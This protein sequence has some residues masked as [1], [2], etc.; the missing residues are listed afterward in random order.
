MKNKR[1]NNDT[2]ILGRNTILSIEIENKL[3]EHILKLLF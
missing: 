2:K 3:V 1:A